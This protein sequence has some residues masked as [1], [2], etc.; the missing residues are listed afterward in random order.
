MIDGFSGSAEFAA[1][2]ALYGISATGDDAASNAEVAAFVERF[3]VMVL[4]RESDQAGLDGW[5]NALLGGT[6]SGADVA[7]AFSLWGVSGSKYE[8]RR[9]CRNL[10]RALFNRNSD[11]DGKQGWLT[12]LQRG[13]SRAQVIDGFCGSANLPRWQRAT[14]LTL[15]GQTWLRLER[16][17]FKLPLTIRLTANGFWR[18]S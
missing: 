15:R 2:A 13:V 10:Y 4:G 5:V 16:L 11:F 1:L 12:E 9:I 17:P 18:K 14:V 3:Y 7:E 6:L 8:R